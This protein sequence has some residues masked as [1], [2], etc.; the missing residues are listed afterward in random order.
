[1]LDVGSGVALPQLEVLQM[2]VSSQTRGWKDLGRG[3]VVDS[4]WI[5]LN[6][7]R[8]KKTSGNNRPIGSKLFQN[9]AK[10]IW[11]PQERT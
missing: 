7:Q 1:M 2:G 9:M 5:E 3:L 6:G 11:N 10:I 4:R 8:N